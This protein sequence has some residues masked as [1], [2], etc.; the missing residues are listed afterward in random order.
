MGTRRSGMVSI[1]YEGRTS[2]A[3]VE[4]LI[5]LEVRTLVDV[6]MTPLSRK[7]GL[8]KRALSAELG[9]RSIRYVHLGALGNP[10]GNR[11]P[12]R[13][14]A[15]QQGC[16][17]FSGL[18]AAP[19]AVAAMDQLEALARDERTAVLCFEREHESCHRQVIV[20]AIQRRLGVPAVIQA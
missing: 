9:Q 16:I 11:E 2:E 15:V 18:L 14:G 5:A 6:R 13:T 20:A 17:V 10:P 4:I 8:S 12:F 7:P 1:G 3:L 19:A